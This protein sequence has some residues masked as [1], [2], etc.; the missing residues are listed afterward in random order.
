MRIKI[1][2]ITNVADAERAVDSAPSMIGLNFYRKSPRCID[3]ATARSIL[4]A[5]PSSVEPVA[6]FVNEPLMQAQRIAQSLNIR[7]VQ[8]HGDLHGRLSSGK[9]W[10]AA[11][12][13]QDAA[14][15]Q[16]IASC[17]ER[18]RSAGEAPA[19]ILVDAH[20]PGQFGGTGQARRGICSRTSI[21]ACR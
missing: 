5:L 19:S 7:T 4:Q 17:L 21:P 8:I 11:F 6:L 13:V 15:L 2:G 3:E 1:C 9:R 20:V 18:I 12:S 14:S 16:Q 10:I